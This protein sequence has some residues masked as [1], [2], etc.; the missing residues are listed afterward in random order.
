MVRVTR[1]KSGFAAYLADSR[2]RRVG[3]YFTGFP[4]ARDARIFLQKMLNGD[5]QVETPW[6]VGS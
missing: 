4:S 3:S 5:N 2:G 1:F 6:W